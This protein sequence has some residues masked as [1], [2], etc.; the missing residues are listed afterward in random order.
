MCTKYKYPH[1]W[2]LGLYK[3][4]I[5]FTGP[6]GNRSLFL[7]KIDT[8]LSI[9]SNEQF[10]VLVQKFKGVKEHSAITDLL[11][12]IEIAYLFHPDAIFKKDDSKNNNRSSDLEEN[13]IN[14][15]I[16]SINTGREE[17]ERQQ[18]TG[19]LVSHHDMLTE[20]EQELQKGLTCKAIQKKLGDQLDTAKKQLKKG[21][22]VYI[23]WDYDTF[24]HNAEGIYKAGTF[25][26]GDVRKIIEAGISLFVNKNLDIKVKNYYFDEIRN[27]VKRKI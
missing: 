9:L 25:T 13:G 8:F 11:H 5:N 27:L 3:Y 19:P 24:T 14:I 18:G 12:E 7:S 4:I 2:K 10:E 23:I 22:I 21:G 16:K 26:E 17:T 15:E 1:L 6:D 20:N